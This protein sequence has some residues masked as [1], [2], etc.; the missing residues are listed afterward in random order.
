MILY[1]FM[2]SDKEAINKVR[3]NPDKFKI[4]LEN[5]TFIRYDKLSDKKEKNI[6][7]SINGIKALTKF[8]TNIL[9]LN[10]EEIVKAIQFINKDNIHNKKDI[11][12]AK[13]FCRVLLSI[14]DNSDN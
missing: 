4:I 5:D 2:D 9:N 12:D 14:V 11:K 13:E 7:I 10:R 3:S 6:L 8:N 1:K